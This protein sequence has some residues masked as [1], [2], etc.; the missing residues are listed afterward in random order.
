MNIFFSPPS[1]FS[2]FSVEKTENKKLFQLWFQLCFSSFLLCC[3]LF[4]AKQN[5]NRW[6]GEEDNKEFHMFIY[7]LEIE[8]LRLFYFLETNSRFFPACIF[9]VKSEKWTFWECC[10]KAPSKHLQEMLLGC[11]QYCSC[12][13]S[14]IL[15]R[16][17]AFLLSA[18]MHSSQMQPGEAPQLSTLATR[19]QL[20]FW[21][22]R[23]QRSSK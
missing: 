9:T 21:E 22:S 23:W 15:S 11:D 19:G 17:E 13:P 18:G 1:N 2:N 14:R 20:L 6:E 3:L 12:L 7:I 8:V 4:M 16:Q 5:K 10:L